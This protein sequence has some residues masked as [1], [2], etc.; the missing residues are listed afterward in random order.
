MFSCMRENFLKKIMLICYYPTEISG[1]V[2]KW[3]KRLFLYFAD[4]M[5]Y[6]RAYIGSWVTRSKFKCSSGIA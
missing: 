5:N 1:C 6:K 3:K 2:N 4:Q